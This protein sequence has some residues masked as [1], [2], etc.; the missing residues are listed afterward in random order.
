VPLPDCLDDFAGSDPP[1]K[2]YEQ[3]NR[4]KFIFDTADRQ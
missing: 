3:R 4:W 1:P 2:R